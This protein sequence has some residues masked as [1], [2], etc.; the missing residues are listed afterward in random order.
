MSAVMADQPYQS[1]YRRYRPQRFDEVRGQDHITR[2]LRNAV[3]DNRVAHAYLFSGPRGTGKTSTARIL[4]KALNC[5]DVQDGEPCGACDSCVQVPLGSSLDV[6]EIDAASNRGIDSVRELIGSAMLGSPGRWK[7]YIVD[8][9]HMLSK[10]ASAALLKTLEEP[11]AHV[12]FVLATTDPQKV[13]PTIRSRTQHYEFRLMST[14]VLLG[15]VRDIAV[16]A[17]LGV[18]GDALEQVVRRGKGSARDAL[19]ILDQVA[20]VGEMGGTDVGSADEVTAELMEALCERDAGRALAAVARGCSTGRDPRVVATDLLE[21]LR[22]AFLAVMAPELVESAVV[23]VAAD[24]G[25]RLGAPGVVRAMDAVGQA[26]A[27]MREALEPRVSLEVALVRV[28]RPDVDASPAALLERIERLERQAA[29]GAPVIAAA[30]SPATIAPP[31]APAPPT[32]GRTPTKTAA[33]KA[34]A[35]PAQTEADSP[36]ESSGVLPTREELTLAWGDAVLKA[37][38]SSA[39]ART[40]VGRFVAVEDGAARFALPNKAH[41]DIAEPFRHDVEEALAAHFGVRVPLRFVVDDGA[42]SGAASPKSK[43]R[44]PEEEPE[45][46]REE[47]VDATTTNGSA[48]DVVR[49]AF[50]GAEEVAENK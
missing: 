13:L 15:L 19:S 29:S 11:P 33:P 24:Q 40:R 44:A 8:E 30:S 48:E 14:E 12:V 3:R 34:K 1:L 18:E 20:A 42:T 35:A 32:P 46:V 37:L 6:F 22:E 4:A 41:L 2:A 49:Q 9:V 23:E 7:V 39:R 50:P 10:E 28:T 16:D 25:R 27:D 31:R 21:Q 26:V 43:K 36:A 45:I 38:P 17:K 5:A 47:L